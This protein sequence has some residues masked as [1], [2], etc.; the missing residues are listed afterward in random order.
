MGGLRA[1]LY[2]ELQARTPQSAWDR[3]KVVI[4]K[5]R[6][7]LYNSPASTTL[8]TDSYSSY[9]TPTSIIR[10]ISTKVG[11]HRGAELISNRRDGNFFILVVDSRPR[12]RPRRDVLL[13]V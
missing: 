13:R 6:P 10:I 2:Q 9:H 12:A 11:T 1:T 3:I 5:E 8:R 4:S 7:N